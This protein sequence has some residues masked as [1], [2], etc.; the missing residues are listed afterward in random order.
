MNLQTREIINGAVF[1]SSND[2]LKIIW[3]EIKKNNL[4]L[5]PFD[6]F[7]ILCNISAIGEGSVLFDNKLE[8]WKAFRGIK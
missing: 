2:V 1:N 7:D 6:E 4:D 8:A 3:R 5:D